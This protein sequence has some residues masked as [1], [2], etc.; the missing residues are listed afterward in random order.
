M[1]KKTIRLVLCALVLAL[2]CSLFA[3]P[4]SAADAADVQVTFTVDGETPYAVHTVAQG[5]LCRA[6]FNTPAAPEGMGA[7]A[8]WQ[9]DGVDFSFETPITED[10]TLVA[11][12]LPLAAVADDVSDSEELVV[13]PHE[14][15]PQAYI[16]V[17]WSLLNL[18]VAVVCALGA[19]AL[20]LQWIVPAP[21]ARRGQQAGRGVGAFWRVLGI[22]VGLLAPVTFM[23]TQ[24]MQNPVTLADNWTLIMATM[25]VLQLLSILLLRRARQQVEDAE[26][27]EAEAGVE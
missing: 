9:L 2:A 24:D 19:V 21:V 5:E 13:I 18:A 20:A 22:L 8:A 3:L 26:L 17:R 23:A 14:P 10:I 4:V 12:F 15:V 1:G 6:P 16:P 27:V 7:F 11:H 25:L